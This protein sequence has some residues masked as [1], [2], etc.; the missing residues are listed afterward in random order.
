LGLRKGMAAGLRRR[1]AP[2][3]L[4]TA[5]NSSLNPTTFLIAT[6]LAQKI[7]ISNNL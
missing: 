3:R 6:R 1:M 4:G 5:L 7:G 2:Q